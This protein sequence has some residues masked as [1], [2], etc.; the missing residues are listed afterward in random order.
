M[1]LDTINT[2]DSSQIQYLRSN[3]S[4]I[5][6]PILKDMFKTGLMRSD[7]HNDNDEFLDVTALLLIKTHKDKTILPTLIDII[8]FRNRE[9][10][11]THDLI[12]AF[13]QARDPSSLML[14]ANYL[15]SDNIIDVKLACKLLDFVPS[16]DMALEKDSKNLY[17]NFIYYLKENIPFL[18]YTGESFQRTSNPMPYIVAL[19]A[20]YLC[21]P[22][23]VYTGKPLIPYTDKENRISD[24]FNNLD[25]DKKLLL[26]SYSLRQHYENIYLWDLWI[27]KSIPNQISIT[28]TGLIY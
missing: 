6:Y 14:I 22:I 11:F 4:E 1:S 16:I 26:S 3:G 8:F 17:I 19:D 20:K 13:F 12:W 2:S 23:S 25:E 15:H 7:L 21:R 28:Q 5:T 9:G 27:N 18:Y 10:L 24:G